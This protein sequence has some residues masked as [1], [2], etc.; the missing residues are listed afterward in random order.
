[1]IHPSPK[2]YI[3]VQSKL[4]QNSNIINSSTDKSNGV[5]LMQE[6]RYVDKIYSLLE[7]INTYGMSNLI[8]INKDIFSFNKLLKKHVKN[9]KTW[10]SLIESQQSLQS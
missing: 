4:I 10:M 5:V 8:T 3:Q 9:K 2:R 6:Q 1:M 7:D